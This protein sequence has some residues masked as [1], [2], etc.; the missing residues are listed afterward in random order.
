MS[1]KETEQIILEFYL[2]QQKGFSQK[3]ACDKISEKYG[4]GY[5]SILNIVGNNSN[6]N[7]ENKVTLFG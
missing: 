6:N 2:L 4:R 7:I 5:W 3:S 1:N